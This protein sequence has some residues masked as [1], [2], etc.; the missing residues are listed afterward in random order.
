MLVLSRTV[1][2]ELILTD[3]RTGEQVA[4]IKVIRIGPHT[5]RLGVDSPGYVTI[6]RDE[7]IK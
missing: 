7:L 4:R 6:L 5:V 3:S 2:T 1:G